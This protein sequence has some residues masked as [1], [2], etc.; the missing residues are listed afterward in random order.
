MKRL[1]LPLVVVLLIVIVALQNTDE[2]STRLLFFDVRLPLAI[3]LLTMAGLG[4]V[5]GIAMTL[6]AARKR[7]N[8]K[9]A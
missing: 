9:K 4:F 1:V 2:V 5:T 6:W 7:R 8:A 3:L